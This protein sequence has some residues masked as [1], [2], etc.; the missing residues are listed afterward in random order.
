M[1]IK[2]VNDYDRI[3]KEVQGFERDTLILIS[4]GATATV[5]VMDLTKWVIRLLISDICIMIT[6][7][8]LERSIICRHFKSYTKN[9]AII[10]NNCSYHV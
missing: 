5:M 3:L 1:P 9:Q 10:I 6:D 8:F 4:L 7:I 2:N